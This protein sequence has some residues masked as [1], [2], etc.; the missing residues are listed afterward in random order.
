MDS[1]RGALLDGDLGRFSRTLAGLRE[2]G[3]ALP[4]IL[5]WLAEG[6]PYLPADGWE[7]AQALSWMFFEQYTHEPCIAV[8][9]FIFS[10]LSHPRPGGGHGLLLRLRSQLEIDRVDAHQ[11]LAAL[12][13]LPCIHQPLQNLAGDAKSEVALYPRDYGSRE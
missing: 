4:L 12:D 6:T 10:R 11:G 9:R 13:G 8:A 5:F 3:E 1:L 2:Q 7:R